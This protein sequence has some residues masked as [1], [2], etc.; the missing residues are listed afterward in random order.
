MG[1]TVQ[2]HSNNNILKLCLKSF[3][4]LFPLK[5]ESAMYH[6]KLFAKNENWPKIARD[7]LK[8]VQA[9]PFSCQTLIPVPQLYRIE[10]RVLLQ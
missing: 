6:D 4:F 3:I 7:S 8:N 1:H 9:L 2:T 5:Y 10:S